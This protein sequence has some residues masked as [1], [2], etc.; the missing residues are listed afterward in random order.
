MTATTFRY[1]IKSLRS[2]HRQPA[3]YLQPAVSGCHCSI[4]NPS[5]ERPLHGDYSGDYRSFLLAGA[6][7]ASGHSPRGAARLNSLIY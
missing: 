1:T 3:D 2:R 7:C 5:R 6:V 4:L